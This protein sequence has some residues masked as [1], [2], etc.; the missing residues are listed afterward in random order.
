MSI[1][2]IQLGWDEFVTG[3]LEVHEVLGDQTTMLFEPHI[4]VLAAKLN[5]CLNNVLCKKVS[6]INSINVCN[7]SVF[8]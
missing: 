8:G 2:T 4:R 6:E 5:S 7:K 3:E 1:K